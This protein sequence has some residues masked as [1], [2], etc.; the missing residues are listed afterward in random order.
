MP[1]EEMEYANIAQKWVVPG[2]VMGKNGAL[3]DGQSWK[4]DV[5][6]AHRQHRCMSPTWM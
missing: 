1:S 3:K 2:A 6:A 5:S 4:L